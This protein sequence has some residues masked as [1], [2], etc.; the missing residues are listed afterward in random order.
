[1]DYDRWLL[2]QADAYEETKVGYRSNVIIELVGKT[3]D[4]MVVLN[5][6][7]MTETPQDIVAANHILETGVYKPEFYV[8]E[9]EEDIRMVWSFDD[10]KWY[11]E[12]ANAYNR[13]AELVD[14]MT[15]G[16]AK[17]DVALYLTRTGEDA[18]D[19]ESNATGY[20]T[21]EH[22]SVAYAYSG[23][24]LDLPQDTKADFATFKPKG[25]TSE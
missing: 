11:T 25:V 15:A 16:E 22:H 20:A 3:E 12:S 10:V 23:I 24:N 2:N 18:T 9:R 5:T 14:E 19:I 17:L 8:H 6:Y 13:L 21:N 1:M 7:K 4:V